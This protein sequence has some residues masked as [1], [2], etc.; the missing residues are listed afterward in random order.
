MRT[1]LTAHAGCRA[2]FVARVVTFTRPKMTAAV[3][4][5]V[6]SATDPVCLQKLGPIQQV[7]FVLSPP[8]VIMPVGTVFNAESQLARSAEDIVH[9]FGFCEAL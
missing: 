4:W 7:F 5:L 2:R 8:P 3:A 1:L 6:P 9:A